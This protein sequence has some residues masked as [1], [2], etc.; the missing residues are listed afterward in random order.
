MDISQI[1]QKIK[2]N[3][4]INTPSG[5]FA[6]VFS[7]LIIARFIYIL[8]PTNLAWDASV[9]I[10]MAK[11]IISFGQIGLWEYFRPPILPILFSF[12][13][14][15]NL[16][17]IIWAQFLTFLASIGSLYLI[18]KIWEKIRPFAGVFSSIALGVST[19]F[20][21]FTN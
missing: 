18:Y 13:G 11:Y 9:Y 4:N 8:L 12:G 16:S 21:S 3:F 6:V 1:G 20:F 2:N 14:F 5:L 15:M 17:I 10:G 19:L 7:A